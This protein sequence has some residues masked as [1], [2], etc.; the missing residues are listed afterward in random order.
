VLIV[1]MGNILISSTRSVDAMVVDTTSDVEIRR[2]LGRL[3]DDLESTATAR[4]SID[5]T[6]AG[7]DALDL[8]TPSTYSGSV[9]WGAKD[10]AGV[11]RSDWRARYA[12]AG[13]QLVRRAINSMGVQ[14][15]ADALLARNVD[16]R[17]GGVKGFRIALNGRIANIG[18]R[19][20][21]AF[22][23]GKVYAKEFSTSV[24][25]KNG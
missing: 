7:A 3:I 20:R 16:G 9:T 12:V 23:D 22:R 21:K 15:G 19:V 17:S 1:V 18:L 24:Q 2:S 10:A 5:A 14:V 13:T 6:G 11:W 8:Q 4:L 25:L